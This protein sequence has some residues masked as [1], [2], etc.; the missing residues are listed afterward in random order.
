M[1]I[2]TGSLLPA[3]AIITPLSFAIVTAIDA[4][5]DCRIHVV[6]IDDAERHTLL[7]MPDMPWYYTLL[8]L[9]LL[10][11]PL[12]PLLRHILRHSLRCRWL[13]SLRHVTA[14]SALLLLRFWYYFIDTTLRHWYATRRWVDADYVTLTLLYWYCCR[15]DTP[16]H[17]LRLRRFFSFSRIQSL[18]ICRH[19][20]YWCCYYTYMTLLS[21]PCRRHAALIT[22]FAIDYW[23]HYCWWYAIKA[24]WIHIHIHIDTTVLIATLILPLAMLRLPPLRYYADNSC[25]ARYASCWYCWLPD[26][27]LPPLAPLRRL[28]QRRLLRK[29]TRLIGY[30]TGC[31]ASWWCW[32]CCHWYCHA[33][34][35]AEVQLHAI[36]DDVAAAAMPPLLIHAALILYWWPL[37]SYYWS[38]IILYFIDTHWCF[39]LILLLSYFAITPLLILR[40]AINTLVLHTPLHSFH[41]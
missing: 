12:L 36:I 6:A 10:R 26:I 21:L 37:H 25:Y 24:A 34:D 40:H 11:L 7:P 8:I 35:Y 29:A 27:M 22:P 18:L 16:R 20:Y 19:W 5:V 41:Y 28:R 14:I 9:L 1:P 32:S 39:Q 30:A 3:A 33:I 4:A 17:F 23:C 38:L 2:I 31:Y 15:Y 13:L